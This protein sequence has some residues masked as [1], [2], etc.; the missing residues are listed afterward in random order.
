[1][2]DIAN[3]VGAVIAICGSLL[4]LLGIIGFAALSDP[5]RRLHGAALAFG[6][7]LSLAALGTVFMAAFTPAFGATL[8]AGSVLGAS[9][10]AFIYLAG[11]HARARGHSPRTGI[12]VDPD[13]GAS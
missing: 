7:G 8:L 4:F 9:G 3:L 12:F 10:P 11:T 6:P 5:L 1:M 2:A 13:G